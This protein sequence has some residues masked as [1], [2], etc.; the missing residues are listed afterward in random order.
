[1]IINHLEAHVKLEKLAKHADTFQFGLSPEG[2]LLVSN[3]NVVEVSNFMLFHNGKYYHRR[4]FEFHTNFVNHKKGRFLCSFGKEKFISSFGEEDFEYSSAKKKLSAEFSLI[5]C[6][7]FSER[8]VLLIA[9]GNFSN[10]A[11][12]VTLNDTP[13]NEAFARSLMRILVGSRSETAL[14]M[15]QLTTEADKDVEKTEEN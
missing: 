3:G 15:L 10:T 12:L 5:M 7:R 4:G 14:K 9:D 1:M 2:F 6:L 13:S 8:I 11:H